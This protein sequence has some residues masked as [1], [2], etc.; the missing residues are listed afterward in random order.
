MFQQKEKRDKHF[1]KQS[2]NYIEIKN[3]E[4]NEDLGCIKLTKIR[5]RN[6]I[7]T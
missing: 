6:I 4:I 5:I 2:K 3:K 7:I 1:A